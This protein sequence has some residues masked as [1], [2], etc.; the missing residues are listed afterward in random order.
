MAGLVSARSRPMNCTSPRAQ[1]VF[2]GLP[3]I[4]RDTSR[5]TKRGGAGRSTTGG[6]GSAS[7]TCATT[8]ASTNGRGSVRSSRDLTWRLGA[9]H[10]LDIV[11]RNGTIGSMGIEVKCLGATGNAA[12]LTQ[13]LG[14]AIL[15]LANRDRTVLLIHCGTATE[16]QRSELRHVGSRVSAGSRIRLIVVPYSSGSPASSEL[17][18]TD[19][20]S[21][22]RRSRRGERETLGRVE[23]R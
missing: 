10:R 3:S 18:A 1:L 14:Q 7:P 11:L 15:G 20:A 5:P 12:K 4:E 2:A 19:A 23:A 21:L 8:R 17:H 13:G 16:R 9:K 6:A 22:A